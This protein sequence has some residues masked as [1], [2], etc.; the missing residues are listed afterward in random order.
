M[1]SGWKG[2]VILVN[3]LSAQSLFLSHLV[4]VRESFTVF[5]HSL[6]ATSSMNLVWFLE[7]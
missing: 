3:P 6:I 7:S 2:A 4:L 1:L 5:L